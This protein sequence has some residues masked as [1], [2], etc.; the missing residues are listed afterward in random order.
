MTILVTG[1]AGFIGYHTAEALLARGET[2][3][4]LDIVN[5]YYDPALKEARL[6][7]LARRSG[8]VEMR[9][10]VADRPALEDVFARHRPRG[11]I[12]LAA[13]AGVRY[14]VSNPHAYAGS[15]L[16]GFLNILECSRQARVEHL[17]YAST[18]SVYGA[19]AALPFSEQH[20]VGHPM[21]LYAATKRANEVMAHSYAHLY[22]LPCTG[23]RFFTVYGP[24]GRP[25]MALF[26][27]TRAILSGEAIDV[28]NNGD[29]RRDFT[30]IDDIVEG[31][32]RVF[33]RPARPDPAWD[34]AS[35]HPDPS[36]SGIAPFRIYNI[37][38]G[39]PVP[40]MD[41]IRVLEEKL[42]RRA[43]CNMLPMQPGDVA[44]T[45][46]DTSALARDT[47]YAPSTPV[48]TGVGRFVDWYREYYGV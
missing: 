5:D 16:V 47:G 44:A 33:D 36:S 43:I 1:A 14:S 13:Q 2:V 38:R 21:S 19:N 6:A 22:G 28:Y 48:E 24:W 20:G 23:L 7:R 8:F 17:V 32:V 35:P 18:S 12:H 29:M 27:F 31:V 30:Y 9:V 10:D 15:N 41:F 46:A 11:V 34:A 42:G 40:L 39:S 25:D 37:G 3:V 45:F 26:K 4:G